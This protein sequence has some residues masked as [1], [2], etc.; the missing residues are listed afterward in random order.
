MSWVGNDTSITLADVDTPSLAQVAPPSVVRA[1]A[2]FSPIANASRREIARNREKSSP[3]PLP[4]PD[5]VAPASS[6]RTVVPSAPAATA[7]VGE[8]NAAA[9]IFAV[10]GVT[11]E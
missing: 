5:Q 11:D 8:A 2:P 9:K 7:R 4:V 3:R 1:S 10:E 6:E